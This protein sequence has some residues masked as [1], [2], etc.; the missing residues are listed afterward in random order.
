M[1]LLEQITQSLHLLCSDQIRITL[2]D[3]IS[4]LG[5]QLHKV[6]AVAGKPDEFRPAV[7]GVGGALELGFQMSWLWTTLVR[8][9][10]SRL[11]LD[12]QTLAAVDDKLVQASGDMLKSAS[13]LP[14]IDFSAY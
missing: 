10:L 1:S 6:F 4:Y 5:T 2:L 3:R 9:P 13:Y 11:N 7:A 8:K 14:L 12:Q